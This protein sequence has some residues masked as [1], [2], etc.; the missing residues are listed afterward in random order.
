MAGKNRTNAR[1]SVRARGSRGRIRPSAERHPTCARSARQPGRGS[2]IPDHD[3]IVIL[4]VLTAGAEVR[5]ARAQK[6]AVDGVGL[7]VH[8]RAAALD[9]HVVRE[10]A[11]GNEIMSLS[12]IEH[13]PDHDAPMIGSVERVDHGAIGQR[14]AREVDGLLAVE[15]NWTSM[16]SK[17]SSGLW[18]T[19]WASTCPGGASAIAKRA[20][21]AQNAMAGHRLRAL[22]CSLPKESLVQ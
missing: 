11:Q 16:T 4:L 21:P 8:E 6:D 3:K 2:G 1:I 13:D 22:T 12:R 18:W 9:P 20:T 7:Q 17:R 14:V 15:I 10:I 5:R 19:S